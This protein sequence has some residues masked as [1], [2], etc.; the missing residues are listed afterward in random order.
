MPSPQSSGGRSKK[1][2]RTGTGEL[3]SRYQIKPGVELSCK[4]VGAVIEHAKLN[5]NSELITF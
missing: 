3:Y 5:A 2:M 4:M 1:H